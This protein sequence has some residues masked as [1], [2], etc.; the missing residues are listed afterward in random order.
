MKAKENNQE[1]VGIGDLTTER[2][3]L[4]WEIQIYTAFPLRTLPVCNSKGPLELKQKAA[5]LLK[6]MDMKRLEIQRDN[7]GKEWAIE[8]KVLKTNK[9]SSK[10]FTGPWTAYAQGRFRGA[11]QKTPGKLKELNSNFSCCPLKGG[12]PDVS[13]ESESDIYKD[14]EN[15]SG[16]LQDP[17]YSIRP[18]LH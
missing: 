9:N 14:L 5:V 17:P 7:S 3:K 11:Q 15:A 10:F 13:L 4:P 6:F 8:K 18:S 16:F 2:N 12:R 1:Q